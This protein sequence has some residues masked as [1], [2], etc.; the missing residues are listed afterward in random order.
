V[1][2]EYSRVRRFNTGAVSAILYINVAAPYYCFVLTD[3]DGNPI[4]ITGRYEPNA[5]RPA[6]G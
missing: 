1:P 3:P 2:S 4:E 6:G 5:V